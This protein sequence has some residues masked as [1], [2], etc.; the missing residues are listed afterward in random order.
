M[1]TEVPA[2]GVVKLLII[3]T[4]FPPA[5][6]VAS[7]R[8]LS[9]VKYLP[10]DR[11]TIKVL[12]VGYNF[13]FHSQFSALQNVEVFYIPNKQLLRLAQF[14]RPTNYFIHK[15]KALYNRIILKA[16]VRPLGNWSKKAIRKAEHIHHQWP[17]DLI[18]AS[19]PAMEA[20]KAGLVVATTLKRP[21]IA[22]LRDGITNN[23]SDNVSFKL[24][25]QLENE[26]ALKASLVVSVSKPIL[27]Y[28]A[29]MHP[30][31]TRQ[32]AEIRNGFDFEPPENYQPNKIFTI[33]YAGKFYGERK[34]DL[35]FAAIEHLLKNSLINDIHMQLI[36]VPSNYK[37]SSYLE[38]KISALPYQ[39]YQQTVELLKKSDSLLLILGKSKYK[40]AYSGKLFDYL[41]AQRTIIAL[42]DP[43]DVAAELI[44]KC[45]AGFVA[46]SDNLEEI[47][48][49]ILNSYHVW[50]EG[51]QLPFNKQLIGEHHRR[52]Q[53]NRL[54]QAIMHLMPNE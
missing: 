7:Q 4:F 29:D 40:G 11:Y 52:E 21:L 22:D 3:S 6:S 49:A 1:S 25:S 48:M 53:T 34:P 8:L 37:I 36:G 23:D 2:S 43:S 16:G 27:E 47:K 42:C 51:R 33:T 35:F 54:H 44:L 12:T 39:Q 18:L 15:L 19:Y 5:K 10:S 20:L 14:D 28:F 45:R 13:D 31:Y 9:F 30:E 46:P 50:A 24:T 38:S 32:Y 17:V 41:G 26:V